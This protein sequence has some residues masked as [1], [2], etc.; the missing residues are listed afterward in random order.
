MF[1]EETGLP[2]KSRPG[3][4]HE[5]DPRVGRVPCESS[6]GCKKGHWKDE[7][8]LNAAQ[9][10]VID[11]FWS[12]ACSGGAFLS[13]RERADWWLMSLFGQLEAIRDANK[14]AASASM[15]GV[16]SGMVRGVGGG[17]NDG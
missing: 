4:P 1:D 12:S 11:L 3:S 15:L 6:I 5:Y 10:N 8:D 16:M 14:R 2:V 13:Q 9:A 7:P 17:G